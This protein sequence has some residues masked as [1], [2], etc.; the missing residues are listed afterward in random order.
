M[1]QG[2]VGGF[3]CG[4]SDVSHIVT[5]FN[6]NRGAPLRT[7]LSVDSKQG[8]FYLKSGVGGRHDDIIIS[9]TQG[10]VN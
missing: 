6:S 10:Y 4:K 7:H 3:E 1:G 5:E 8:F 2:W 9:R